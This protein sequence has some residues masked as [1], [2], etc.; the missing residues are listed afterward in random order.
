MLPSDLPLALYVEGALGEANGKMAHGVLRYSPNPIVAVIDTVHAGKDVREM[1]L[2]SYSIPVVASIAEADARGAK[3]LVLGIAPS[4]GM[5]PPEWAPALDDAVN[6]G[7]LLING[8][9]ERLADRYPADRFPGAQVWDVRREPTDLAPGQGKAASLTVPR[10]LSVGT[11]MA[12]GKM[13]ASL[14][15]TRALPGA[16]FVASG[17]IGIVVSGSGVPL[18]AIRVDYASGAIERE[19]LRAAEEGAQWIVVEG[20]GSLAHPSSTATLP[21]MRGSMPTHLLL[22]ARAGQTHLHRMSHVAIPPLRELISLYE[23]LATVGGTFPRA[24]VFGIAL[25]TGHFEEQE[26]KDAIRAIE[27]ET[28]LVCVDPVRGGV[29]P[30]LQALNVD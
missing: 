17:Q 9:H 27:D 16:K 8:L 18:D 2:S 20:Q 12:V 3:A 10:I 29:A 28:G 7:M 24:K 13:T 14:E 26:A 23:A 1:G 4:G 15:L 22:C 5:I 21:L 25:N 6:R 11:D 30:L 19:V